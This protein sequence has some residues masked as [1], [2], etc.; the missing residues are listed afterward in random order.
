[1]NTAVDNA[2]HL[3]AQLTFSL[4]ELR[5]DYPDEGSENETP[6]QRLRQARRRGSQLALPRRCAAAG[7]QPPGA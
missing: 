2:G 5:Y 1:M 7:A 3:A 6:P 4:D